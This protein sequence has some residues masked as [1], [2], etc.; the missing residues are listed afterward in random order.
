MRGADQA[1]LPAPQK[2]VSTSCR[3]GLPKG[4]RPGREHGLCGTAP[5]LNQAKSPEPQFP[6]LC[7]GGPGYRSLNGTKCDPLRVTGSEQGPQAC[8]PDTGSC[9]P[10][11]AR[12]HCLGGRPRRVY[13]GGR[14][15]RSGRTWEAWL[16][17]W[18]AERTAVGGTAASCAGAR[19]GCGL[20]RGRQWLLSLRAA[21]WPRGPR[22]AGW[23]STW[24]PRL[25]LEP[26]GD[27]TG[28]GQEPVTLATS[29]HLPAA[30]VSPPAG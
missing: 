9:A 21:T 15:G 18:G 3:W 11:P 2:P 1:L 4:Q 10:R 8:R 16:R 26:P 13:L 27:G 6:H 12:S 25:F 29:G 17:N 14:F 7:Q 28:R 5:S 23:W 24:E 20:H 30:S 22:R 19:P